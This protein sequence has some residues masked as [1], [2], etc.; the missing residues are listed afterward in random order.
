MHKMNATIFYVT[1]CLCDPEPWGCWRKQALQELYFFFLQHTHQQ[2]E[3]ALDF[4]YIHAR[5]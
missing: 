4:Y 3:A 5:N 1:D 2:K